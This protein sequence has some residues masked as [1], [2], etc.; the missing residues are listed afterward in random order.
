M[1]DRLRLSTS[2]ESGR[3]EK[4]FQRGVETPGGSIVDDKSLGHRTLLI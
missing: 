2:T 3:V 4:V 1:K